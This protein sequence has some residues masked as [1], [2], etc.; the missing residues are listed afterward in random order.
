MSVARGKREEERIRPVLET[1]SEWNGYEKVR[2]PRMERGRKV[3]KEA[4]DNSVDDLPLVSRFFV[5]PLPFIGDFNKKKMRSP[6]RV[7]PLQNRFPRFPR[8]NAYEHNGWG[9][10]NLLCAL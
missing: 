9:Q 8:A 5:C 6:L 10:A 1:E 3:E 7:G 2:G 4:K